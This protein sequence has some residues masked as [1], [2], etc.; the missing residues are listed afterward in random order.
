MDIISFNYLVGKEWGTFLVNI[1]MPIGILRR[2][3]TMLNLAKPD[4]TRKRLLASM[5]RQ[6]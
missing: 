2:R 3:K 5:G 6:L 4:Q 1:W